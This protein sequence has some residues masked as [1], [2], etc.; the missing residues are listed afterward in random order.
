MRQW[1][2]CVN[3][4]LSAKK[5]ETGRQLGLT[6]EA[7]WSSLTNLVGLRSSET[8]RIK[9]KQNVRKATEEDIQC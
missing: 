7:G 3:L 8:A 4:N 5:T 1:Y 9:T 2:S 6:D